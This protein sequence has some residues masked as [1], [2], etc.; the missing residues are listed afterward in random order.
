[1]AVAH[2]DCEDEKEKQKWKLF[3]FNEDEFFADVVFWGRSFHY[4]NLVCGCQF[5]VWNPD[6]YTTFSCLYKRMW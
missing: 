6:S 5:Q 2:P 3:K 4:Y 1:M